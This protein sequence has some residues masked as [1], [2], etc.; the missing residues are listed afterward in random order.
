MYSI[1]IHKFFSKIVSLLYC[2][3]I[4]HRGNEASVRELMIKWFYCTY[5]SLFVV[6]LAIGAIRRENGD[7]GIFL[8]EIA[9]V[10]AVLTLKL[11]ILIWKQRQILVLL[12]R[13]GIFFIKYDEDSTIFSDKV[14]NF[15]KFVKIFL[16]AFGVA[17]FFEVAV[18]PFLNSENTLFFEIAFPLDWKHNGLAFWMAN[19]FL[20]TE[21]GLCLA[22]LLF[23]ITVWYLM[24]ICSLRYKILG[25]ELKK[26][27]RMNEENVVDASKGARQKVFC[28]DLKSSIDRYVGLRGLI[29][30]VGAFCSSLFFIQFGTSGLCICGSVYSL[31]FNI[32]DN[33]V[34]RIVHAYILLYNI[35]EIFM[36]THFG[37]EIMLS[38]DRLAYS[39]FE[40]DWINQ[41][42]S[43]QKIMVIF[44]EHLK[45]S[46]QLLVAKL[47][48][49]TLATF[50]GIVRSAYSM[51]NI[52]KK[53]KH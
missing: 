3:G 26:T 18:A 12:D 14:E 38:S 44:S 43:T 49:L 24:L 37:N 9:L 51:F 2:I 31:A 16:V 1:Q 48:P 25:S 36:I 17:L 4:W 28:Q 42:Q 53:L 46:H 11:C 41:P 52:L 32:S 39:L 21:I 19:I 35:S 15:M 33:L 34:E 20:F 13:I 10:V 47:Y 29:N 30:E 27:G 50:T 40:S 45:R 23:A 7:E 5:F 8:M 6:S 22:P